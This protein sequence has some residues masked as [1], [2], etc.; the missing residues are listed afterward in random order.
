MPDPAPDLA[1]KVADLTDALLKLER[2][3]AAL[4]A[5]PVRTARPAAAR[6]AAPAPEEEESILPAGLGLTEA[7]SLGGRTFLVLAGAFVLRHLTESQT[8]PTWLGV[9]LGLA[10]AGTWLFMADVA[11]RAGRPWSAGFHGLATVAVGLPLLLEAASRFK[12][13]SPPLAAALLLALT[14]V[15]LAVAVRRRLHGLAWLVTVGGTLTAVALMLV[16]GRLGPATAYLIL[17][18]VATLWLGYVV[19]WLYLRWPVALVADLVMAFLALRAG[20]QATAEGPTVALLVQALLVAGYFGSFAARTLL[21]QRKVVAFEVF[22]TAAA[23]LVGLGGAV[24]VAARSG[25]GRPAL[26]A[27]SLVFGAGAYAVAFAFVER[28]QKIRENFYFYASVALVFTL[29]GTT[30][31]LPG[32]ALAVVWAALAVGAGLLARRQRSATLALHAAV[33][34][35]AA[36][37]AGDLVHHAAE[38]L[39]G[40]PEV[41]WSPAGLASVLVAAGMAA[42]TWLTAHQDGPARPLARVPRFLLFLALAL[43]VT[44]LLTGWLGPLLAG[45]PGAGAS[46]SV[47]A[48]VRTAVLSSGAL[49]LAWLGRS[50]RWAEAGWLVYPVLGV[51]GIKI[52]L[53]DLRVGRPATQVLTFAFFGAALILVPR[54]RGRK[55]EPPAAAPPA[56]AA[57]KAG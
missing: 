50:P 22:Q 44:G 20:A 45:A 39:F 34:G 23:I 41:A 9:A 54:L 38:A 24:L 49:L 19:D 14:G 28:R 17:L 2:R 26:G 42:T 47:L 30:L 48:A 36:A 8:L 56:D 10:Y 29:A 4:E 57:R 33:Y 12:L 32:G 52:L 1:A 15:A 16:S 3:V 18:G 51:A 27:V 6:R 37:L 43:S 53:E 21:L 5:G 13:L 31:L 46:P 7:L 35:V 11:G 40:P 55:K 25:S